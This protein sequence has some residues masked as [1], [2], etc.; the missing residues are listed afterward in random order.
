MHYVC[1]HNPRIFTNLISKALLT[2]LSFVILPPVTVAQEGQ[3]EQDRL[4]ESG[5][6]MK[7]ILDIP[8]N[9]PQAL[10]NRAECVIVLPSVKKVAVGIG[11]S[12]GRGAMTCRT[13]ERFDGPWSPPTMMASGRGNIGM[14]IG[15]QATDYVIL[16]MNERGARS[17]MSNKVKLGADASIAAGPKGR[18]ASAATNASMQAEM[19]SYSRS[20]GAFVGVSLQ[21]ATLRPDGGANENLYGKKISDKDIVVNG[22][23]PAPPSATLLLSTLTEHSPKNL[24]ASR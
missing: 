10:L 18:T 11:G 8:D 5:K 12:F 24:S 16:V 15:G 20:R 17:M 1:N 19:L 4:Q 7:E 21:G 14:L 2:I 22:A 23:V 3:R 9:I 6:V 13:G